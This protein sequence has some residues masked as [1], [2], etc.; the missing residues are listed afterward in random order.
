MAHCPNLI[1]KDSRPQNPD[2]IR[3]EPCDLFRARFSARNFQH[4]LAHLSAKL[5]LNLL[6]Y[7]ISLLQHIMQSRGGKNS[8]VRDPAEIAQIRENLKWMR[9]VGQRAWTVAVLALMG[10]EGELERFVKV[11][12]CSLRHA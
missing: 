10:L 1:Q 8:L 7:G 11:G 6:C 5:L 9:D 3:S 4:Q 12:G 2:L